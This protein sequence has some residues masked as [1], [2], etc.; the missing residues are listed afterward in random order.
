MDL[1]PRSG[2]LGRADRP[3][4]RER[5]TLGG[6]GR[7][8]HLRRPSHRAALTSLRSTDPG[9]DG[10]LRS[11]AS[12]SLRA[13]A[14]TAPCR[15]I[16]RFLVGEIE[17]RHLVDSDGVE[18]GGAS[19]FLTRLASIAHSVEVVTD[20]RARSRSSARTTRQGSDH[21]THLVGYARAPRREQC[22]LSTL[23]GREVSRGSVRLWSWTGGRRPFR[24]AG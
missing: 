24:S 16:E 10:R 6:T 1:P 2:F 20:S 18:R 23:G 9:L 14:R 13:G 5:V 22:G 8:D 19:A 21:P 7:P 11:L 15:A 12:G 17:D 3:P 4:A